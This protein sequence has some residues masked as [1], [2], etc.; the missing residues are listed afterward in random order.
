MEDHMGAAMP[1]TALKPTPTVVAEKGPLEVQAGEEAKDNQVSSL[2]KVLAGRMV[3]LESKVTQ[4]A[5]A[6]VQTA[7]PPQ[8]SAAPASDSATIASQDE[9][10][11]YSVGPG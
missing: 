4:L 6:A 2:I 8:A 9:A 10:K 3:A 11:L 7:V 1:P 5:S